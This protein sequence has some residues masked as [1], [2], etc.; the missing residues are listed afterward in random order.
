[1][2][3]LAFRA[4][5]ADNHYYEHEDAFIRHIDPRM[6]RRCMEW[7]VVGGRKR[8]LV[9][10]RINR[11]IPNPTF[12]PVA[13]PGVL[14]DF[15]RGRNPE[16][17]DVA[18][19]FGELDPI[20][21]AFRDRDARLALLDT[22]GLEG[23]Y[24]FPTLAVG[25]EESLKDDPEALCAAFRAFNRWLVEDWGFAYR[26][27]LFAAPYIP[28][29]NPEWA[30]EE[31]EWALAQGARMISMTPGPVR[32]SQH[33]SPGDGVYDAFF[34]RMA[35]AQVTLAIHAGD[36]GY[37]KFADE[38][39][40]GGQFRAFAFDPL[41]IALSAAPVADKLAAM[42]CHGLFSRH[43][44]LRV[45]TIE[46]GSQWLAPL[47]SRLRKAYGQ[48]PMAFHHDP[49]EQLR[50]N[51]WVAPYYEDDLDELKR[52]IGADHILFGSDYPH[53]EGLAQP[54]DFVH[55]CK[56]YDED[57]L[58]LVMRENA[59]ALLRPWRA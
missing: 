47:L 4:F 52:T 21:P 51:V 57:E 30:V 18:A 23:T 27:R 35:E 19:L 8:L 42:V 17:K 29:A 15:F 55:D 59:M 44:G 25:M 58:R 37:N 26:D 41:R 13:R 45:A 9:G 32:G 36:A 12:D 31:L 48:M 16:G 10:G 20:D 22:Q 43:P 14:D 53:A 34:S 49:V 5:D 50:R 54:T 33:G 3:E 39:G 38:Y 7:A 1:M 11:F 56:G 6:R 40:S 28:L 2:A 46:C 24:L